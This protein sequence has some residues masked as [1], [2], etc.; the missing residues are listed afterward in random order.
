MIV[1]V[2]TSRLSSRSSLV[3][4]S[5]SRVLVGLSELG[6]DV[7][8]ILVEF[9]LFIEMSKGGEEVAV[10]QEIHGAGIDSQY[11]DKVNIEVNT[12]VMV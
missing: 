3:S 12:V 8:I 5:S 4:V 10:G 7:Y 1:S 11:S 6:L 2:L 9:D